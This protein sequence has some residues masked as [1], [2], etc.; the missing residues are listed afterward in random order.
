MKNFNLNRFW[1]VL[2]WT[3]ITN[4]KSLLTSAAFYVATF[5]VV[6]LFLTV[7]LFNMQ[8]SA[9]AMD[10]Q[11]AMSLCFGITTVLVVYHASGVCQDL[12]TSSQ[13]TTGLMLPA[14][15]AEKYVARLVYCLVILPAVI[16]LCVLAATGLRMLIELLLAHHGIVF[17]MGF[18]HQELCDINTFTSLWGLSLF[19][20]G[21]TLFRKH[22]F[23]ITW[24]AIVALGI[25]IGF[26]AVVTLHTM[27]VHNLSFNSSNYGALDDVLAACLTVFNIWMS[28]WLYSRLQV[29]QHKWFN[30]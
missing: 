9:D 3:V 27:G 26:V 23:F 25:V 6:Q 17:G 21:G 1:Q 29:V 22:P 15:I 19:V 8:Q 5:L 12:R 18:Y 16:Y 24:S 4:K 11:T 20:L 10:V 2:R 30:V 7:S 14:S 28:Y 13:R